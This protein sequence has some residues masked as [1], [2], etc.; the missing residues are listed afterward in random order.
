M[1]VVE[2]KPIC[3]WLFVSRRNIKVINDND[4]E[5]KKLRRNRN[6]KNVVRSKKSPP[7]TSNQ[8]GCFPEE[9]CFV[10][11]LEFWKKIDFILLCF[12]HLFYLEFSALVIFSAENLYWATTLPDADI[13]SLI[14][15]VIF[16]F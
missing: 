11:A 2:A 14:N 9:F 13:I 4:A 8:V 7:P 15:D 12:S 1:V 16:S 5:N 6:P 3:Y 10:E